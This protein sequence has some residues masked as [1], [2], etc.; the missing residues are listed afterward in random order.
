MC[1]D[2]EEV[3]EADDDPESKVVGLGG[4]YVHDDHAENAHFSNNDDDDKRACNEKNSQSRKLNSS[5]VFDA[6]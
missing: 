3:D 1:L 6:R 5:L 2:D 4:V